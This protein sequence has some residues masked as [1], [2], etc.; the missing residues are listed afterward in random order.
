M[1]TKTE[2]LS[3]EQNSVDE[4]NETLTD[5][6]SLSDRQSKF[7]WIE[8]VKETFTGDCGIQASRVQI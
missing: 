4:K 7:D 1:F 2:H 3:T 8:M 6:E 5:P